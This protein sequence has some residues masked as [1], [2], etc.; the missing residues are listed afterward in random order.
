M[1]MNGNWRHCSQDKIL[2]EIFDKSFTNG[3]AGGGYLLLKFFLVI[4]ETYFCSAL[5]TVNSYTHHV[6][7]NAAFGKA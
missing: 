5:A 6:I 7:F 1:V 3:L 2:K 4:A